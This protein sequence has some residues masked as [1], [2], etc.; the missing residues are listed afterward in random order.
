MENCDEKL[1]TVLV[2]DDDPM[3]LKIVSRAISDICDVR[4][5]LSGEEALDLAKKIRPSLIITDILMPGMDGKALIEALSKDPVTADIPYI[6][7]TGDFKNATEADSLERGAADYFRKP[8]EIDIVQQRVSRVLKMSKERNSLILK[9]DTDSLTGAYNRTYLKERVDDDSVKGGALFLVD[10]DHFKNVNDKYGHD[11]GDSVIVG[12]YDILKRLMRRDDIVARLGG[13]EFGI[14]CSGYSDKTHLGN[15]L[16]KIV[17]VTRK[18]FMDYGVTVSVGAAVAPTDGRDFTT[19][20]QHSDEAMY[21]VKKSG[22]SAFLFYGD[23]MVEGAR[24]SENEDTGAMVVGR[25]D[26]ISILKFLARCA[27]RTDLKISL[28]VFSY[29]GS[30]AAVSSEEELVF[31]KETLRVSDVMMQCGQ[32][33]YAVILYGADDHDCY[34]AAGRTA[35]KWDERGTKK[36][37]NYQMADPDEILSGEFF[38]HH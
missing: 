16:H 14:W 4:L 8:F 25:D 12:F 24:E 30:D 15:R 35:R 6:I 29:E 34:I 23:A 31:I 13:D 38:R 3:A 27:N 21:A 26:F 36:S 1:D 5:S 11:K 28:A 9:A 10:L 22:K 18:E 17:D 2:V 7:M 33:E 19:L 20:Y 32:S 37:L